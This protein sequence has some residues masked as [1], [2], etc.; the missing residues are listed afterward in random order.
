MDTYQKFEN[1]MKEIKMLQKIMKVI[2]LNLED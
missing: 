1:D 2:T